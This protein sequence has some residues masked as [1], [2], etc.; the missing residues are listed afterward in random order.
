MLDLSHEC[1]D[2]SPSLQGMI[3]RIPLFECDWVLHAL[4]MPMMSLPYFAADIVKKP[5]LLPR[6]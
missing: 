1:V 4:L 6:S 3:S 5:C 2:D